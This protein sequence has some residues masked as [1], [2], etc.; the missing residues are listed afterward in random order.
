MALAFDAISER[1]TWKIFYRE[2]GA[3]YFF[4]C[5]TLILNKALKAS[6]PKSHCSANS[7]VH[8]TGPPSHSLGG[9]TSNGR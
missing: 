7:T 2:M 1:D 9:Q 5:G 6:L 8:I 3:Q 4:H